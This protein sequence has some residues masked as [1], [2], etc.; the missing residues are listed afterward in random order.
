M[1]K[2]YYWLKLSFE[3]FRSKE[4]KKLNRQ[5]GGD[6]YVII[7]LQMLLLSLDC[8]GMIYYDGIEDNIVDEIALALDLY[9][10]DVR[11]VFEYLLKVGLAVE[12]DGG[13]YFF[14]QAVAM[15]GKESDS[16]ERKRRQRAREA[17]KLLAEASERDN[18]TPE[19]D[20]VTPKRDNVQNCH[21]EKDI[22][23]E[24]EKELESDIDIDNNNDQNEKKKETYAEAFDKLWEK[25]PRK[26]GKKRA[27]EAYKR[28]IKSGTTDEAIA[29]GIERYRQYVESRKFEEKYIKQGS[30]WFA[31]ECWNDEYDIS[32]RQLTPDEE[33]D[34][35]ELWG[36]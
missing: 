17:E 34:Y 14:P 25:Y 5:A 11:V 12:L 20:N 23:I 36:D 31:G 21:T 28:A 1:P 32:A 29:D 33:R 7:Y 30:T 8:G 26:I 9:D 3:F 16:A 27:F 35:Q 6:K 18:V 22:D 19:R 4:V 13:A 15:T 10:N 2:T 24:S